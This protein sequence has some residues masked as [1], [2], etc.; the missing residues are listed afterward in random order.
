MNTTPFDKA[1]YELAKQKIEALN[2]SSGKQIIFEADLRLA[3][4]NK[5]WITY[6]KLAMNNVDN[7]Y[8]DNSTEY[9]LD[10]L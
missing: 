6:T 5:D 4:I 10:Y 2:L 1:K 3:I 8:L 7:Y 9:C